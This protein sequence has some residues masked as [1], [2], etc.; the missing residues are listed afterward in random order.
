MSCP[1]VILAGGFGTRLAER[2][3]E[4][5]KPMVEVG[6]RPILWHILKFY[7]CHGYNDFI[8]ACGYKAEVIK[9][10]FLDYRDRACDLIIDYRR[11]TVAKL[12]GSIEPWR[13]S[14]IDTG[15]ETL[16]GGRLKRLEQYLTPGRIDRIGIAS[17]GGGGRTTNGRG[18][19][20]S[21][22]G[23][24]LIPGSVATSGTGT[25]MMT[26]G[27]GVADVDLHRLLTFHRAH[28]RLATFTAV[29]PPPRFGYPRLEGDCVIDFA[30][31]PGPGSPGRPGSPGSPQNPGSPGGRRNPGRPAAAGGR[32]A[33][34]RGGGDD[35]DGDWINGGFFVLEPAVLDLIEGDQTNFEAQTLPQ[36][37]RMGQLMAFR[38]RGFWHPM[39]TLRDVRNLN[40]MWTSGGAPW[41]VWGPDRHVSPEVCLE[42]SS[43]SR[44]PSAATS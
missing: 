42:P 31:K 12:N 32:G 19:S 16:T 5:P 21:P 29:R 7:G 3:D 40:A 20:R 25:F 11:N 22:S 41:C 15:P 8:I 28:G 10:F 35:D 13:I 14:L 17:G 24:E 9:R 37:A 44:Q 1:V 27:D 26:Y 33:S 30:E 18:R 43:R 4:L 34:S 36:L 39:D 23:G 38:H 2:T 6:G